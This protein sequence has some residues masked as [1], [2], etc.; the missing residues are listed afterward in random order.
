MSRLLEKFKT[1][2][3]SSLLLSRTWKRKPPRGTGKLN[4]PVQY[5]Q[6]LDGIGSP[7]SYA[8]A[9]GPV[10]GTLTPASR[11][12]P[13]PLWLL[14]LTSRFHPHLCTRQQ[15]PGQEASSAVHS[16]RDAGTGNFWVGDTDVGQSCTHAVPALGRPPLG[17]LSK[18]C[19]GA[20]N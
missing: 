15:R 3:D 19:P 8:G 18:Q 6:T 5:P 20:H 4:A 9:H 17:K 10:P 13:L 11:P 16:G 14:E 7:R 12:P 2:L 1:L